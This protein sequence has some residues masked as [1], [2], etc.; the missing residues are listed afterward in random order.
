MAIYYGLFRRG[1]N[2]P[3]G[4][5]L[6]KS[7]EIAKEERNIANKQFREYNKYIKENKLN[8]KP[9]TLV[10]VKKVNRKKESPK[11]RLKSIFN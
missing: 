10:R 4:R 11:E 3:M 6:Y 1:N 5:T 8:K 7:E 2:E 9:I